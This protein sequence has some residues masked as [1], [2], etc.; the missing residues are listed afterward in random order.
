MGKIL[1]NETE[2]ALFDC[3]ADDMLSLVGQLAVFYSADITSATAIANRDPLYDE[4]IADD[5]TGDE[6]FIF[7]PP[8]YI[9]M[10]IERPSEV[11]LAEESGFKSLGKQLAGM[12]SYREQ[13]FD[14]RFEASRASF[15]KVKSPY[16]K[17]GD[18]IKWFD[19]YF[20]VFEVERH[21]HLDDGPN[22]SMFQIITKRREKFAPERR[23]S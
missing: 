20:D 19:L 10:H 5:L 15:E 2:L 18:V 6:K 14:A 3:V 12:S 21:G 16:P 11:F 13:D 1:D 7:L 22:H 17:P 8:V 23:M 9:P 4:P